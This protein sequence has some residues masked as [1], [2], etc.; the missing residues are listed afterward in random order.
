[1][2]PLPELTPLLI[3]FAG[4]ALLTLF[5]LLCWLGASRRSREQG[6][7]LKRLQRELGMIQA[8]NIGL[9][10][11]LLTLQRDLLRQRQDSGAGAMTVPV[12]ASAANDQDWQ[13]EEALREFDQAQHLLAQG[14]DLDQVIRQTGLT[15]SEA[16]LIQLLYQP[17]S[18]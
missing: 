12:R 8:G 5:F 17:Q 13:A 18:A 4:S 6:L 3:A 10:K 16:E 7:M 9:G 11:K 2:P 1:M 15:R 14:N